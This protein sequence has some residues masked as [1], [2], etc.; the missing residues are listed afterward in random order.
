MIK[1]YVDGLFGDHVGGWAFDEGAPDEHL[2][3]EILEKGQVVGSGS[4]SGERQDLAAAGMGRG[5]HAFLIGVPDRIKSLRE[6]VIVARS[7]T[8]GD[9]TLPVATEED[10]MAHELFDAVAARYDKAIARLTAEC[11]R[12]RERLDGTRDLSAIAS[13]LP[14]D[15]ERRLVAV[16]SRLDAAEVFFVRIDEAVRRLAGESKKRRGRFLGIF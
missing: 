1:G 6:L 13:A 12:L 9:T 11:D 8:H 3:I 4:A 7:A 15:I 14:E 5:D 16:E 2:R 10:R